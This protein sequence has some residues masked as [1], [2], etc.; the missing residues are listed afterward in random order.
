MK[1]KSRAQT[2]GPSLRRSQAGDG[3]DHDHEHDGEDDN[4]GCDVHDY[5]GR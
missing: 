2:V 1:A 3:G 4:D 5:E